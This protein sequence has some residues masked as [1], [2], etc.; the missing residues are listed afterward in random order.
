MRF[1]SVIFPKCF[2]K[3]PKGKEARREA[4]LFSLR[5]DRTGLRHTPTLYGLTKE[6]SSAY[7]LCFDLKLRDKIHVEL[8]PAKK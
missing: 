3:F 1:P 2:P 5:T 8:R 4:F 6:F 7:I